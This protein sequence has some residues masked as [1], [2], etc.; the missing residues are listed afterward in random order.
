[1]KKI[2]FGLMT[3]ILISSAI[4]SCKKDS[5]NPTNNN[6]T[7]V[8]TGMA[9]PAGLVRIADAQ[10][11]ENN[12]RLVVYSEELLHPGYNKLYIAAYDLTTGNR[13]TSGHCD[14][15]P[16][17]IGADTSGGPAENTE[18]SDPADQ[19]WKPN[20]VFLSAGTSAN[21]ALYISFHNHKNNLEGETVV[22]VAVTSGTYP[23]IQMFMDSTNSAIPTYISLV[24]PTKP[25][26]GNNSFEFVVHQQHGNDSF[27][28]DGGL[29]SSI[30]PVMMS[31]GHSSPNNVDPVHTADG[32]YKGTVVFTMSGMWRVN[33]MLRRNGILSDST[34]FDIDF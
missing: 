11:A 13:L 33:L 7:T 5:D 18:E 17:H 23:R 30:Y 9:I 26:V 2:L 16:L 25:V 10:I 8:D 22:P 24:S 32:H 3:A 31:M 6:N 14:A 34:N 15:M 27:P 20:V 12:S 21:R 29:T 28:F 19:L 4:V 1:M